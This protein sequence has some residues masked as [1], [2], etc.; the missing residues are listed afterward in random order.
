MMYAIANLME[1]GKL[2]E[3]DALSDHLSA[4]RGKLSATLYIW[5]ARDQMARLGPRL[6]VALR[7]GDWDA[8]LAMLSE[9]NVGEGEKTTN[10]RFLASELSDYAR[11]MKVL[12]NPDVAAT[13]IAA[14]QAASDHMDAGLWHA[15]KDQAA[16]DA[17][18]EKDKKDDTKQEKPAMAVVMPDA[19]AGPLM[20]CLSIASLELQAGV[21]AA[22]G[23]LD[24][25][26][27]LYASAA[28]EEK[29]AGYHEPPFYIRPV[30]ENEATALLRAKD[31]EGARA[32]YQSALAERPNSG[33]GLYGLARVAELQGDEA[34]AR[35]AY[36]TFLKAWP[37]AD[38]SLP[39]IA[40]AR[41]VIAEQAT[42]TR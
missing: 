2:A 16:K 40:H 11:G 10:L 38:A 39:E 17:D 15:Q 36:A 7:V 28:G 31:Y 20:K 24:A 12:E 9:A 1:Q 34:A 41:S 19:D 35:A 42:G 33:F 29:K 23:K 3:A 25:A 26:K 37:A 13:D 30:G 27:K 21:L 22:Q 5:S 8:V 6:P 32:S 4:A 14:A 18:K